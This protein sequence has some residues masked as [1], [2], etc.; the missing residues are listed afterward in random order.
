MGRA[1]R[2]RRPRPRRPSRQ[3]GRERRALPAGQ[4]AKS[5]GDVRRVRRRDGGPPTRR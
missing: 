4:E 2:N 1:E 5:Q 3:A